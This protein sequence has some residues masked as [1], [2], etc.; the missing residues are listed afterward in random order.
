MVFK[1]NENNG[2]TGNTYQIKDDLKSKFNCIWS[3][4]FKLWVVPQENRDDLEEY[5]DELNEKEQE[6]INKLWSHALYI[7][8]LKFVSK[9]DTKN[10]NKV[11]ETFTKLL[12][13]Q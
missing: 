8:D 9:S 2:V 10:Y 7:N 12:R 6:K 11:K 13:G 1:I 4:E 5:L 3:S